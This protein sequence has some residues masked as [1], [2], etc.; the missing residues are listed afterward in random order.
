Y[1]RTISWERGRGGADEMDRSY[2]IRSGDVY[3]KSPVR[4]IHEGAAAIRRRLEGE[5]PNLDFPILPELR[6][7]GCTDYVIMAIVQ[8]DGQRNFVSWA[9]D[10]PGGFTTDQLTQLYDLLPLI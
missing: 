6:A 5:A 4:L 7:A 8:T 9:T 1:A 3:L 10:A 2:E